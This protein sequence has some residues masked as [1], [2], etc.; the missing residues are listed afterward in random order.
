MND[1]APFPHCDENVLHMPQICSVCDE[2]P[3]LQQARKEQAVN[4]TS[5]FNPNKAGCPAMLARD[6]NTINR[7]PGNVPV[8]GVRA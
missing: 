6:L 3:E 7:W 8:W 1:K 2:F 4:F 5:E